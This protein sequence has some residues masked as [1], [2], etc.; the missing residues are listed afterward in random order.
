MSNIA[1]IAECPERIP[2]SFS[3]VQNLSKLSK[4]DLFVTD[5]GM[6]IAPSPKEVCTKS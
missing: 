4:L 1:S 6:L 3:D 5:V 2:A